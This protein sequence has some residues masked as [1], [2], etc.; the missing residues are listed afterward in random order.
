M[1]WHHPRGPNHATNGFPLPHGRSLTK[2]LH[3][4]SRGS[5]CSRPLISSESKSPPGSRETMQ[6]AQWW[7][8]RKSRGTWWPGNQR[9][10][11]GASR[12]GTKPP[13]ITRRKQTRCHLLPRLPNLSPC[14]GEWPQKET[15]FLFTS[16]KLTFWTTSPVTPNSRTACG[17][18]GAGAPQAQQDCKQS[19]S[20]CSWPMQC[21]KRRKRMMMILTSS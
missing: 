12:A 15:P 19:T 7:L 10:R 18:L 3:Y 5:Y 16:T 20:R 21:A 9:K 14:M 6:N 13:P 2:G 1:W 11:G 4:N 8:R 17:H